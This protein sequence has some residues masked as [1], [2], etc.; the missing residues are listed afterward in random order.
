MGVILYTS[1]ISFTRCIIFEG[2]GLLG[3]YP[4]AK[5]ISLF[6][7]NGIEIVSGFSRT[8]CTSFLEVAPLSNF[9]IQYQSRTGIIFEVLYLSQVC[10]G[11][12]F[13]EPKI[14]PVACPAPS[15]AH[16][17]NFVIHLN[18][19]SM[20]SSNLGQVV[21]CQIALGYIPYC[22]WKVIFLWS[23]NAAPINQ[24]RELRSMSTFAFTILSH[25][26]PLLFPGCCYI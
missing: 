1:C 25:T 4:L 19:A 10:S 3:K 13:C 21:T 6:C 16:T 26:I 20:I 12:S 22:K 5:I 23:N 8:V 24:R 11:L 14:I 9:S 18:Y 2:W 7:F 17:S 15:R